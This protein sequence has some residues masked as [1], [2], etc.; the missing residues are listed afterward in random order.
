MV[1][2]L[3]L[4]RPTGSF[5]STRPWIDPSAPPR[6][7]NERPLRES[8][9][10]KRRVN[11]AGLINLVRL[12]DPGCACVCACAY[13][14][15]RMCLLCVKKLGYT[16]YLYTLLPPPT[17]LS[18]KLNLNTRARNPK[19]THPARN[20]PQKSAVKSNRTSIISGYPNSVFL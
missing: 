16:C 6:A 13:V 2:L 9:R 10:L 18:S 17:Y 12:S 11:H 19:G 4:K 7:R 20:V 15:M 3:V 5:A 8:Q 14:R 1:L